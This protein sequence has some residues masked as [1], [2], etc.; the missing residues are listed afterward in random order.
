MDSIFIVLPISIS[1]I[2]LCMADFRYRR[3]SSY[4]LLV[5]TTFASLY[6]VNTYGIRLNLAYVA[7]GACLSMLLFGGIC[8]YFRWKEGKGTKII[9]S[10]IGQGDLYFYLGSLFVF[11]PYYLVIFYVFSGITGLAYFAITRK[12]DIP[13]IG[14]SVPWVLIYIILYKII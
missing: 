5:Y 12:H 14:L 9:D 3:V 7:V 13:M 11:E 1:A 4:S 10:K 6:G 2:T 8:V